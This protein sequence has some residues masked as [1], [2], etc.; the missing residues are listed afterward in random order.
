MNHKGT[1]KVIGI[2][3][4][5][6]MLAGAMAACSSSGTNTSTAPSQAATQKSADDPADKPTEAA[7]SFDTSKEITVVSRE[8]GSGTRGAFI[9]LMKVEVKLE[10]G[11]KEDQTTVEA[12]IA[13]STNVVMTTVASSPY[14]IGYISLGSLNDTVKALKVDGVEASMANIKGGTY[15][16]ARP[17]NIAT[18]G[19]VSEVAQDF[20]NF[21]MS[22]QGQQIVADNKY[23]KFDDNAPDYTAAGLSGK[24]VVGG[25]SSVSPLMEKLKEAYAALNPNVTIEVQTSDSTTGV[26]Q[27]KDGALDIGMASRELKDSEKEVLTPIVIALDGIAVV[28]NNENTFEDLTSEQIRQIFVGEILYWNEI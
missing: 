14:A 12:T 20:I 21:I 6:V 9:E 28:V 23:I 26:T 4:I 1:L 3:M 17:F 15:K 10:D 8:E 5:L 13:N 27:A 11:T 24:V 7:S 25:S 16:V 18:K 2:L 22:A 19:E